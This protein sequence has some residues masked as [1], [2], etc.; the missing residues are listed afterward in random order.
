MGRDA[1]SCKPPAFRARTVCGEPYQV[2]GKRLVPV[3]RIVSFGQG[4]GTIGSKQVS[5]RGAGFVFTSPLALEMQT[6]DG[7]CRIAIRDATATALR[8]LFVAA[9]VITVLL[10]AIRCMVRRRRG[11]SAA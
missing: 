5:G 3:A 8:S 11:T 1:Q 6:A 4:K 9:V 7:E 10:T 2:Y